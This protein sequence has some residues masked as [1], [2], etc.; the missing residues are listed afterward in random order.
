VNNLRVE[1][2]IT[3]LYEQFMSYRS[4]L[5]ITVNGKTG[6]LDRTRH[7]GTYTAY[8]MYFHY[9]LDVENYGYEKDG[10]T[11]H[12]D[13]Q[14]GFI[15]HVHIIITRS[16]NVFVAVSREYKLE[17][18]DI[19]EWGNTSNHDSCW[20]SD[21]LQLIQQTIFDAYDYCFSHMPEEHK[22][23]P[24]AMSLHPRLCNGFLEDAV[25]QFVK[26]QFVNADPKDS[27]RKTLINVKPLKFEINII[28]EA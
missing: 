20:R 23:A 3:S 11:H 28:E 4:K 5:P 12:A 13:W 2:V 17:K 19:T 6:V 10:N 26:V 16:H 14:R 9:T 8:G 22:P 18:V 25:F 7:E 21:G 15:R 27:Y 24:V 1:Q